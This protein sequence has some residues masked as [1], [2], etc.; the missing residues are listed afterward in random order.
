MIKTINIESAEQHEEVRNY[1]V[2]FHN[3]QVELETED[4]LIY[5]VIPINVALKHG[6]LCADFMLHQTMVRK[7]K[8][9]ENIN[10]VTKRS[11]V[12]KLISE[13][14]QTEMLKSSEDMKLSE[15]T[16]KVLIRAHKKL[17]RINKKNNV[18]V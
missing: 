12:A 4:T 9:Y 3:K 8:F 1:M 16:L 15:D 13:M 10:V 7:R 6:I 17:S 11:D 2:E 18:T 14:L 5:P